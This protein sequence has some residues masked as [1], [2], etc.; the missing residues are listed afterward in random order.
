MRTRAAV[1]REVGGPMLVEDL[2][3]SPP[4]REEVLVRVEAAGVCHSDWH[5]VTGATSHP[6]PAAL[7]HEGAG[8]VEAL[9]EGV[10]DL[11]VGDRVALNWA[12]YCGS[13]ALCG[14]G[15]PALCRT[16]VGPL[17]DGVM[18]DGTPRLQTLDGAPV[19]H[20]SGLACFAERA[21]VPASCCVK[22]PAG[23]PAEVAALVGCAV[24]TG[25]GAVLNTAG[26]EPGESVAVLGVG[27]VGLSA[28]LGARYAGAGTVVAVDPSADRRHKAVELGASQVCAPDE[29]SEV[30]RDATAG[31]GADWVFE[32]VGSADVQR[33][34][35]E[36]TRPGGRCV[37]VGLAPMGTSLELDTALLVREE[38]AVLGCYYG[39][40]DPKRDLVRYA[41]LFLDGDLPLDRLV[42]RRWPLDQ[43]GDA[44]AALL[45]GE[46]ARG[47]VVMGAAAG[48]A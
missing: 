30:V 25:V 34:A 16:F 9:G 39:S 1:V 23:V 15:S 42:T 35:L 37:L 28:V 36:V 48:S 41:Q 32:C 13:C 45:A 40:C 19:Y 33:R 4:A 14:K 2:I 31:L 10:T 24:T 5:L 38:K 17:W 29:A 20:Y 43:I 7:G 18:L 12:P 27:G 44:Y 26:V 21:V 46:G 11:V 47:V 6:L 8:V 22:I 3:L